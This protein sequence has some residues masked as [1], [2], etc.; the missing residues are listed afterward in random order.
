MAEGTQSMV[1]ELV[2]EAGFDA[3]GTFDPSDLKLLPEV[4]EMCNADKCHAYGRSWSC[5]PACGDLEH[6]A[7]LFSRFKQG[8]LFQTI[9]QME[10]ALDYWSIERASNLHKQRFD[11]LA[12]SVVR[13]SL[14][15]DVFLLSAGTCRLCEE[16]SYPGAPCRHPHYRYPSMEATGLMVNDVCKLAGVPYNHGRN[17]L[18]FT[19]CVLY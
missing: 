18:A 5:P 2:V 8:I 13:E 6:F 4:R 15:A 19:S 7:E 11:A 16:C 14:R 3:T 17:T 12:R 1:S 9:G 10:D